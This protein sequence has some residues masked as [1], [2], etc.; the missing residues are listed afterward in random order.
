MS[1]PISLVQLSTG[2]ALAKGSIILRPEYLR[3]TTLTLLAFG[4]LRLLTAGWTTLLTP[5]Y[6]LWPVQMLGSELDI[7]G[8]AFATLLSAEYQYQG[9]A[10]QD[11]SFEVL[12]IAGMLSGVSAAGFTFG[13]PGTFNFNG[14]KYNVSTQGI[15]PTIESFSGSNG[16]PGF[17]G[18]R[19]GFSGGN[20]T[21]NVGPIPGENTRVSPPQGFSRNYSMLQQGLTANVS[22]RAIGS[23]QSLYNWNTSNTFLY[24]NAAASNG[25]I[26]GLRLWN[27]T[28]NCGDNS[29]KTQ[30]YV[31]MV[32]AS[33][34]ENP[35]GSGFLPSVVCSGPMNTDQ[36]YTNFT[37]LSQGFYKYRFLEAS[38]CEVV[39]LL[40]TVRAKYNGNL[41]S[42]E[43]ISSRPFQPEN[44]QLLSFVAGVARFQSTN[45]QGLVS[46]AIGDT[47][48]S[49]YSST[50]NTSIDDNLGNQ[51]QVYKELEEYWRGVV[52]F[53]A[54]FL[55]SGFMVVGSFPD[56]RI[57]D[58]LASTVNG[59][60]Y[61]STI[62]WTR[63]SATYL[64]AILPITLTTIL[65]F[66]CALY[67]V[68][69]AKK[70]NS[71][72]RSTFDPSNVLH[73][74]MACAAG[75]LTLKGFNK[76]GIID[77]EEVM[78]W[79]D[80][81]ENDGS[82]K[83]LVLAGAGQPNSVAFRENGAKMSDADQP[84]SVTS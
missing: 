25:S 26:T 14:A 58:N 41:I 70:E 36:T 5:T 10:I 7:T 45:S 52:E 79:L 17:N 48:Y 46:S 55:R 60:M 47:L 23:S 38:V 34:N 9:L 3:L 12:D 66:T 43:V 2:V 40:T 72:Y 73:L 42:S 82:V 6:F 32:D 67:S 71:G 56:N 62:G 1:D 15:V 16:V 29:S 20:V 81:Y 13:L 50:T 65:T 33:G 49:I 22:C 69:K 18:T 64:L 57:P 4:L 11:N 35:L 80:E 54:S 74:I 83:K 59:T 84:D 53:S 30:E 27:T 68:L 37:I 31:T 75:N 21:V 28:A 51:T 24:G 61:I 63:Q 77:N 78:V 76:Q 44:T 19:L 39:P 8:T